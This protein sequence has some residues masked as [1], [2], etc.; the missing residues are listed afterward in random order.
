[1][2]RKFMPIQYESKEIIEEANIKPGTK[3]E[4]DRHLSE[5]RQRQKR[6]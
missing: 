5:A 4:A 2:Q 6:F 1:M 3:K